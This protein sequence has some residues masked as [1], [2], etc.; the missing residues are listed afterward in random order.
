MCCIIAIIALGIS[1]CAGPRL[2]VIN[3]S[4]A[5]L[6][7]DAGSEVDPRQAFV[8]G[9]LA[10]DGSVLF[11]VPPGSRHEQA[12]ER[13]GSIFTQRRLGVVVGLS[14]GPNPAGGDARNP[15]F[16]TAYNVRLAPPGPY[17]L[18]ITGQ[19]GTLEITRVDTRGEP[20][21]EDRAS[22]VPS[23]AMMRWDLLR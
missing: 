14:A 17:L 20:M 4:S 11:G 19:P 21:P 23:A 1:G 2:T 18:R 7:L 16:R 22:I 9:P 15:S 5:W 3:E 6:R 10:G 13:G 12:L 8:S